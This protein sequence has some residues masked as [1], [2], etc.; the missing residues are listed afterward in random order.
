MKK[1]VLLLSIFSLFLYLNPSFAFAHSGSLKGGLY[2]E[3]SQ[4]PLEGANVFIKDLNK[5]AVTD[6]FGT[7]FINDLKPGT[8]EISISYIGYETLKENITII[9]DQ[10]VEI[11]KHLKQIAFNLKDV[12]IIPQRELTHSTI[13]GID[14]NLRPTNSSQDMLRLVPGLFIAQH[15]GG[16]KAEQI[17]LRGFDI[18]HGTD[19]SIKVD[20]MPVNMV[21]HAHGQGYA[22]L[23]FLIPELV[24]NVAF[25]KGSYNFNHGNF[26]TAASIDFNTKKFLDKSFV[27]MEGGLYGN[28]RTV[29]GVNLL[30]KNASNN[31]KHSAYVVGEY[32]YN[33]GYFNANQNYNRFNIVGKYTNFISSNSMFSVTVSAFRSNWDASGQIPTRLVDAGTINRFGAVDSTEG[34]LTSRYNLNLQFSQSSDDKKGLFKT[35]AFLSYYDFELY[36]NFTF[37]LNDS[38]NGDQIRQ[39]EK[40]VLAGYNANYTYNYQLGTINTKTEL[41]AGFRY[42]NS[43]DNELSRTKNRLTTTAPLALGNINETNVFGFVN[44]TIFITPKLVFNGGVRFDYFIHDYE[45]KLD[46]VYNRRSITKYAFSPKAGI[47]YNFS[48]KARV[49]F[50]FGMGFHTNDTRVIVAR[51]GADIL[52]QSFSYDLGTVV[53]PF[54]KMVVTTSLWLLDLQQEFV[55]VGDEAIIEPSGRTRRMGVDFSIRYEVFKWLYIDGDFNYTHARARDEA[56]GQDFIPLAAPIT[57]IGGV[58]FMYK[59]CLS[60]SVRFRYMSDRPAN[61]DNSVIAKGYA[62]MDAVINFTKPRYEISLQ[63]Q[64]LLNSAW[65]EAQFDTESRLAGETAP[66][67][68]IHFTPGTPIFIKLGAA[69]KF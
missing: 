18:D 9:E 20:G 5:G 50:N 21:S 3:T 26:A 63:A 30:G 56:V 15:A 62:L 39:K 27:K 19:V 45:D 65:N 16:G 10:T 25:E 48:D 6:V 49:F 33:R 12:V 47:Y 22:D 57:A 35:N 38:I 40:R 2:D 8:Y 23:H 31:G 69:Y 44:Q 42:D 34:G 64:N 46:S 41:G 29:A 37:F 7:F 61:E 36:S 1:Q 53:K 32:N 24:D 54:K 52:P 17:F 4:K 43:M 55:Y 13:S 58:T 14:L 28:F 67:S 51:N 68:E 60:A 66:V 59:D 11:K